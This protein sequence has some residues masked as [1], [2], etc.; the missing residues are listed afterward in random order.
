MAFQTQNS[1]KNDYCLEGGSAGRRRHGKAGPALG[2][3]PSGKTA[4][5]AL[6]S[7]GNKNQNPIAKKGEGKGIEIFF[8]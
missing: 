8:F 7:A 2:Q 6:Q 1:L 4:A 5:Y 3:E